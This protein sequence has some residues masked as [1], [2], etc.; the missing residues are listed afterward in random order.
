[1][2][3]T[4]GRPMRVLVVDDNRE[5]AIT[6]GRLLTASGYKVVISFDGQQALATAEQFQPDACLLDI[7]MPGMDGYELARRLRERS[8]QSAPV[9]AAVTGCEDF[10]HLEREVDAG[11]D[12]HFTKPAD[13]IDLADQLKSAAR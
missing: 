5:A 9:I 3:D 6:L 7:N 10:D 8:S 2:S 12:L 1:M 11:F 4:M 13:P